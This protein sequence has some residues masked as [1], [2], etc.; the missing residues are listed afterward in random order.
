MKA[1][2][3][4]RLSAITILLLTGIV[5]LLYSAS[6]GG[7]AIGAG[8]G[9]MFP[10]PIRSALIGAVL[11]AIAAFLLVPWLISLFPLPGE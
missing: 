6:L 10:R 11:G 7:A 5:V 3:D 4:M 1:P 8:I 2:S 9:A